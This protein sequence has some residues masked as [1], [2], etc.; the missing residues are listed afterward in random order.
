M[1]KQFIRDIIREGDR[2][3]DLVQSHDF[4][5]PMLKLSAEEIQQYNN[6]YHFSGGSSIELPGI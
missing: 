6:Y 3:Y 4:H 2:W 5:K 1:A